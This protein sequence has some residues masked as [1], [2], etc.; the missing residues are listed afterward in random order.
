MRRAPL[1]LLLLGLGGAAPPA[2]PAPPAPHRGGRMVRVERPRRA[3]PEAV[4]LCPLV[5]QD[6]GRLICYGATPPEPGTRYAILDDSG[7]RG[8]AT[9][10]RSEPSTQD[11]CRLGTMHDVQV[12]YEEGMQPAARPGYTLAIAVEGVA[13]ESTARLLHDT[14]ARSPSGRDSDQVWMTIDKNGDGEGDLA[15]T[16]YECTGEIH[17][18]PI[19]PGGQR[20]A[21]Y[22][23]EY[24]AKDDADWRK[25]GR[26]LFF[27]CQ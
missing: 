20:V 11:S 10:R 6:Q 12:D 15:V 23:I 9:V 19:A 5:D 14:S 4:R 21:S 13:V 3:A 8:W 24:W 17:D 16:T 27:Y 25:L 1:W 26:D 7:M 18:L 2:P 22:C